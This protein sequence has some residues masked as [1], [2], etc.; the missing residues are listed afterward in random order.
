M[1]YVAANGL[2]DSRLGLS[3][4]KRVGNAVARH[5]I[6]RLIREAFRLSRHEL[7]AGA[8]IVCVARPA[9]GTVDEYGESLRRLTATAWRK[10]QSRT[11]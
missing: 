3:V 6:K 2:A 9:S 10:L 4:G 5:R 11:R 7:P 8:D 1:V